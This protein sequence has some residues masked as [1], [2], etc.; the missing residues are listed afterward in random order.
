MLN[1]R[2]ARGRTA[3]AVQKLAKLAQPDGR[4]FRKKATNV[5]VAAVQALGEAK[6]PAAVTVLKELAADKEKEVRET[7]SRALAHSR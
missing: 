1:A 5:R 7:A 3:D 4:L 2:R 6:T